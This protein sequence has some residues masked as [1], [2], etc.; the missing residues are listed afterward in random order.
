M[1]EP[2][3][4]RYLPLVLD[5]LDQGVFTV[6]E[7][8]CITSFNSV[9]ERLTG[10]TAAEVM[11][12][13]CSEIFRSD[14]C[15][16]T[17]PLRHSIQSRSTVRNRQVYIRGRDG[18]TVPISVSTAPL[19]TRG[20][21]LLGGVEVFRDLSGLVDLKRRL[22]QRYKLVDIIG[23]SPPMR[24][25]FE[26]LP[27]V[28]ESD[29]TVLV[30]GA[31]GTGKELVARTLHSLGPR[32]KGPF[33]AVNCGAI[34]ETLLEAE[35]FG[36]VR[37]AFTDARRDRAGRISAADG[38]ILFLDEIGD[39]PRAM[40]VKVL[41]FLQERAYEPLGSDR[42][43]KADV[44]V[45]AATNRD[46]PDMV[47][48]GDFRED[49]FFRLNVVQLD[50]PPLAQRAEDVP[51][52]VSHYVDVFRGR[53]GKPIEGVDDEAMALLM[54]YPFPG[55]VRELENIIERAFILCPG[56]RIGARCLPPSVTAAAAAAVAA[57]AVAAA[58]AV[59]RAVP[60]RRGGQVEAIRAALERHG[61]NRTHAAIELGIHRITLIRQMRR[62]GIDWPAG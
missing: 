45:V 9:A 31:S 16:Q 30:T 54:S 25:L 48:R 33:V 58:A 21:R 13:R 34:P 52:L 22:D 7:A 36:H 14:L 41:R 47:R 6:D 46:L 35:L 40:Q 15:S 29:S 26:L 57:A 49:L 28:A 56:T 42:T 60:A 5:V 59:P 2:L 11:G 38:G 27:P 55:N 50:I 32:R 19:V 17:C 62:L 23:R 20:G 53:S 10:W 1:A 8:T 37:G 39:L 18:R 43:V 61:G 3:D 24:R 12:R 51:L 4:P 44:R